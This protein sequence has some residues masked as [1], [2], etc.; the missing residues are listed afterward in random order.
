M[1]A[2]SCSATCDAFVKIDKS[3]C[4]G[5][6]WWFYHFYAFVHHLAVGMETIGKN[7]DL[8]MSNY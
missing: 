5:L 6:S 1:R 2:Y 3:P 4:F 7:F 8:V